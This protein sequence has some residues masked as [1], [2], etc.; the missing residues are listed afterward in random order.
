M[1]KLDMQYH[2]SHYR[3]KMNL[4]RMDAHENQNKIII[5]LKCCNVLLNVS[6]CILMVYFR[7]YFTGDC[8]LLSNSD[9]NYDLRYPGDTYLRK[10]HQDLT[11]VQLLLRNFYEVF[12]PIPD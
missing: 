5:F 3:I 10:R 7:K 11:L 4:Y 2:L 9:L 8:R 6:C 1:F 12:L